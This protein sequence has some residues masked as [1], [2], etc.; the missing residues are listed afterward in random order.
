MLNIDNCLRSSALISISSN[1]P[2]SVIG[3]ALLVGLLVWALDDVRLYGKGGVQHFLI[4]SLLVLNTYCIRSAVQLS[5]Y[6]LRS[7]IWLTSQVQNI[8]Q[9]PPDLP[10]FFIK[11]IE[12]RTYL[13]KVVDKHVCIK[14]LLQAHFIFTCSRSSLVLD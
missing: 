5:V 8:Q 12:S 7:T 6:L 10:Y 14:V 4:Q 11:Q 2:N 3:G 1:L 13:I 9:P